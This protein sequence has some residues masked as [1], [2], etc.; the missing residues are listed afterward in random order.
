MVRALNSWRGSVA[1]RFYA[2]AALAIVAVGGLAASPIFLAAPTEPVAT[3][4]F[5]DA[6]VGVLNA[7][8]PDLLP[9]QH[10]GIVESMPADV[11]RTRLKSSRAQLDTIRTRLIDLIGGFYSG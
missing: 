1:A 8:R 5:G 4:L 10:R 9:E 11:D 7:T 3:P 2:L 6:F